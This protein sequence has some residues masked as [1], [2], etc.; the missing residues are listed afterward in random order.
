MKMIT[1]II[2]PSKIDEVRSSLIEI[3]IEGITVSE[4]RG[5]GRQLGHQE[6]YRGSEYDVSYVPKLRIEIVVDDTISEKVAESIAIAAKTN[7]IGDGKIFISHIEQATR[8]R[9]GETGLDAI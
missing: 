1:A 3:G 2:K 9:T 8:I 6:T 7:S 4:V 5:F